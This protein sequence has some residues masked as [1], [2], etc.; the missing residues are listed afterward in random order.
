MAKQTL[1]QLTQ[2]ILSSM[3]SDQVNSITDTV[4]AQQ[5]ADIVKETYFDLIH[6]S[7]WP[8]L[9]SLGRL[10][11]AADNTKPTHLQIP[12]AVIR[13]DNIRYNKRT[14][15]DTKDKYEDVEELTNDEFLDLVLA[16]DSSSSNV[17][18]VTDF[19]NAKIY[20]LNNTAPSYWTSFDDDY[21]VFDSFDN[22]VDSVVQT[23]KNQC[24][25]YTEPTWS[26]TDSFVPD[27]PAKHFSR[28][29]AE[30]KSTAF[31]EVKEVGNPKQEMKARKLKIQFNEE[32]FRQNGRHR[33]PDYGR[34]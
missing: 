10:D 15:T 30:A 25:F 21:V 17:Q 27:L 5:V 19:S 33:Y 3:N 29:L 26:H 8:H 32:K 34:K 7:N 22:T 28:L 2:S 11:S 13:I 9:K 31:I 12:E 20:V 1:L 16:R 6:S 24:I 23:S 4:E 14:S 18:T